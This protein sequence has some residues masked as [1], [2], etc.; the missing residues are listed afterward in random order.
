MTT[1]DQAGLREQLVGF[2][3]GVARP[4]QVLADIDDDLH[5]FDAGLLDSL[6]VIQI[7]LYLEQEHGVNLA[8]MGI[9]PAALAT[10]K[11]IL[12]AIERAG[13]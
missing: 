7:I 4:G 3:R 11:G 9:D 8:A 1:H 5:L 6:A 2:L 10:V 12:N 13:K